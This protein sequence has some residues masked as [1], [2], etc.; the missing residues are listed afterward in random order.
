MKHARYQYH[1]DALPQIILDDHKDWVQLYDEAWQRAFN[2]VDYIEKENWKPQLT[3]M[4]GVGIVWQWDSCFMS[5][6]TNLSNGTINAMNN[7]DNLYRLRRESDGFMS[8]AYEID[9]EEPAYG[10]RINPPLMAWAEWQYYL[11]SGDDSRFENVLPAL[12]G[13]F[14]Y[15]ENNR[16]RVN[17]LYWFE[18][19]GSSGMDNAPR[20]GYE[21]E[22]LLGSDVCFIDLACQQVLSAQCLSKITAHLG[23]TPKSQKY[24]TEAQRIKDLINA[25]HWSERKHFYFDLF[26]RNDATQKEKFINTKTLASAWTILTGVATGERLNHMV[27]HLFNPDEFYTPHPFAT[28]SADDPNFDEK[29]GYWLGSVWAPTNYVIIRGLQEAGLTKLARVSAIKHLQYM[30][31]VNNDA[32]YGNIW[33][34]YAPFDKAPGTLENGKLSCPN[35][36][37]WSGLGPITLLIESI[38]GFSFD[39]TQN[40]VSINITQPGKHGIR[41]LQFNGRKI[42]IVCDA[43]TNDGT[44]EIQVTSEK[45]FMLSVMVDDHAASRIFSINTG[46]NRFVI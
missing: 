12:E 39:A 42:S 1:K 17:G 25:K 14:H 34:C 5:F 19:C 4:P 35:F 38:L 13:I 6:I 28:L 21:A 36:V 3:C 33:E 32:A 7:L 16:R 43:L 23:D 37:G 20:S 27:D 26:A 44:R 30:V 29:G 45:P 41:N 10:E 9:T 8:M 2:N 40:T 11:V 18:D 22:N 15:I 46:E 24:L 31:D